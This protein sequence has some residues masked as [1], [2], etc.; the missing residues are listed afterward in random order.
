MCVERSPGEN[1]ISNFT[2]ISITEVINFS[3][4][5]Q[6]ILGLGPDDPSNGPSFVTSL[7]NLKVLSKS[8]FGL[9][10]GELSDP[11]IKSQLTLGGYDD[12]RFK[13][14]EDKKIYYYPNGNNPNL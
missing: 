9:Q 4:G 6:G 11:S 3:T 7:Y 1:C 5:I 8:M 13:D 2:F 14:P 10:L 12:T